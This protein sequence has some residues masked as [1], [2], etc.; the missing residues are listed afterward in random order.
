MKKQLFTITLLISLAGTM[1][2]MQPVKEFNGPVKSVFS[3]RSSIVATLP[4]GSQISLDPSIQ[5]NVVDGVLSRMSTV[6]AV[7][8]RITSPVAAPK[9]PAI[10]PAPKAVAKM[11]F[12]ANG[13]CHMRRATH[14]PVVKAP[15]ITTPASV[16]SIPTVAAPKAPA[17]KA[18]MR[19]V[20]SGGRCGRR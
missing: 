20:C 9:A 2:A 7:A 4:D 1:G 14:A 18:P 11:A 10:Q 17:P 13:R 8:D 19:F 5:W 6:A 16:P 12:C 3:S 15:A